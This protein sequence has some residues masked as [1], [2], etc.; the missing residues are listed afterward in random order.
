M[1]MLY[2]GS[3]GLPGVCNR[4]PVP[5]PYQRSVP[6]AHRRLGRNPVHMQWTLAFDISG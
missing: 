5:F 4:P 3:Q 2:Q 1:L 6:S